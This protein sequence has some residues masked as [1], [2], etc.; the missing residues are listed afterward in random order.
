[1]SEAMA[2]RLAK[3]RENLERTREAVAK[4]EQ[5][6]RQSSVTVRSKDRTVE[7]TVGPQGELAGLKIA[8]DKL[9]GLTGKQLART[10]VDTCQQARAIMARQVIE[11][12]KPI[13]MPAV[14]GVEMEGFNTDWDRIFG[15]L[16]TDTKITGR[17]IRS[18]RGAAGSSGGGLRD[19]LPEDDE[20]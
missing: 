13:E 3:A 20:D 4:A 9:P 17:Q 7:V 8:E 12:F 1:M 11:A 15:S 16:I 19:E 14:E 2:E 10:I 6:L 18:P 5:R